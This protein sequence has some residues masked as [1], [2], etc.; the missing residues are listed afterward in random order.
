MREGNEPRKEAS[1]SQMTTTILVMPDPLSIEG[2]VNSHSSED[3]DARLLE[4]A[5]VASNLCD[6]PD[7]I[8]AEA[9]PTIGRHAQLSIR[10]RIL[11]FAHEIAEGL[12]DAGEQGPAEERIEDSAVRVTFSYRRMREDESSMIWIEFYSPAL[13][14]YFIPDLS[15][16]NKVPL[17]HGGSDYK[18]GL[19]ERFFDGPARLELSY[20]PESDEFIARPWLSPACS[21]EAERHFVQS[22]RR[23]GAAQG[24]CIGSLLDDV[25][26]A[27]ILKHSLIDRE[28]SEVDAY[29]RLHAIGLGEILSFSIETTGV[30]RYSVLYSLVEEERVIARLNCD[31]L[32]KEHSV[33]GLTLHRAD[34]SLA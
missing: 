15:L 13:E 18:E 14:V 1:T 34:I 25:I 9:Y 6:S 32:L 3:A 24:S 10:D 2:L 4:I 19:A 28:L 12:L 22:L 7:D 20:I 8:L 23:G 27:Y 11:E 33:W 17:R 26:V 5:P 29:R 21:E 31:I 30:T 16:L